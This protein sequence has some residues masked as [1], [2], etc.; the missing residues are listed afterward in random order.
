MYER[1]FPS[2]LQQLA[3]TVLRS[4]RTPPPPI[5]S[6]SPNLASKEHLGNKHKPLNI[7]PDPPSPHKTG[8]YIRRSPSNPSH[9]PLHHRSL[10]RA[11]PPRSQETG[12][13]AQERDRRPARDAK[14]TSIVPANRE[15][16][17][18]GSRG[19]DVNARRRAPDQHTECIPIACLVE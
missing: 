4:S 10:P 13:V 16:C 18:Q 17:S 6:N 7:P 9:H 19:L 1:T 14:G 5:P 3:L 15:Y 12:T 11:I 8:L 2:L